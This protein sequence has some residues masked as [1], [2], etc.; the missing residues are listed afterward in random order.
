MQ[1]RGIPHSALECLLDYGRIQH[2][3]RTVRGTVP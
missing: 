2:D 3:H 1:Q